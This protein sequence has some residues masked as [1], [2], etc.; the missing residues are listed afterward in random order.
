MPQVYSSRVEQGTLYVVST[1]IGNLADITLRAI[2]VMKTVN[3][4]LCEDTRHSSRLLSHHC[5]QV[6]TSPYHDHNKERRTPEI[7]SRLQAGESFAVICDAGTPG[8][9]DAAFFLVRA[10]RREG[11]PVSTAPGASALLAALVASGLP[12]DRFAFDGFLPRK[13]GERRRR[14]ESVAN[15]ERTIVYYCSP[16]QVRA[17]CEDFAAVFPEVKVVLA[18]ELTKLHEEYLTGTGAELLEKLPK[19]PKGEFVVLFHPQ[20]KG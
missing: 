1:P 11:I 19:E 3:E 14:I 8:V 20:G 18:R 13:S 12:T 17:V 6:K 16:Y 4:V 7:V 2:E 15:E 10:C 5:I 9:S